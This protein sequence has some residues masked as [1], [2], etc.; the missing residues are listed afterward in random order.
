MPGPYLRELFPVQGEWDVILNYHLRVDLGWEEWMRRSRRA[1]DEGQ[2]ALSLL[3]T[4]QAEYC[5][6]RQVQRSPQGHQVVR[7]GA[8]NASALERRYGRRLG[9]VAAETPEAAREH[10]GVVI[11]LAPNVL[12]AAVAAS[13]VVLRADPVDPGLTLVRVQGFGR[14]GEGLSAR[15]ARLQQLQ[16]WWSPSS[17]QLSVLSA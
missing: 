7:L 14:R 2:V 1:Y 15:R 3:G 4:A 9:L 5:R 11:H 12:V 8:M 13:L 17:E 16:L 6:Q 10:A